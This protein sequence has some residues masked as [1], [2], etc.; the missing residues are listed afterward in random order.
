MAV[1]KTTATQSEVVEKISPKQETKFNIDE[2]CQ[3]KDF[4]RNEKD[5][6][7]AIVKPTESY[8]VSEAKKLLSKILK[9][10]VK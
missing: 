5:F 2:L 1:K 6:L 8:S 3:S 4:T 10:E 7:K 9:G